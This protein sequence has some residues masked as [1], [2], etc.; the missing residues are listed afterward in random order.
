MDGEPASRSDATQ[1]LWLATPGL[2]IE[3]PDTGGKGLH[4][5]VP[6]TPDMNWHAAHDYTRGIAEG[7]AR[8]APNRYITSAT[9]P[10]AGK[11]FIAR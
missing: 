1:P 11:L 2:T 5:M 8:A 9:V 4:V 10:R 6:I 3:H 7:L